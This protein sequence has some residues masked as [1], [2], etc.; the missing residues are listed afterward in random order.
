MAVK[1]ATKSH[2]DMLVRGLQDE[3]IDEIKKIKELSYHRRG[4]RDISISLDYDKRRQIRHE[5]E[6]DARREVERNPQVQGIVRRAADLVNSSKDVE[7]TVGGSEYDFA[8]DASEWVDGLVEYLKDTRAET[9]C[10]NLESKTSDKLQEHYK[11]IEKRMMDAYL[12][13]TQEALVKEHRTISNESKKL[14][15][16]SRKAFKE[17]VRKTVQAVKESPDEVNILEA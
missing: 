8:T 17:S 9:V 6:R 12:K 3:L 10:S 5:V 7:S 11:S 2:M 16:E 14:L 1:K 13:G 4:R 15:I